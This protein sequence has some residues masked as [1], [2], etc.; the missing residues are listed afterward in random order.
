MKRIFTLLLLTLVLPLFLLAAAPTVTAS[1]PLFKNLDGTRFSGEFTKG[2]GTYRIVVMKE[3]SPVTGLPQNGKD[4]TYNEKFGTAG[5]EFTQPGEFV[6]MNT[7][8]TS[9]YPTNLKPGTTYH[10]A[11]FEYNGKGTATEYLMLPLTGSVTT[12]VAP[13]APVSNLASPAQTGNTITLSWA[14]GNGSGRLVVARKGAAVNVLPADLTD[15]SYG[16]NNL[17][18]APSW[19]STT[20]WCTK[21]RVL[22]WW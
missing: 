5:S 6:V 14:A 11:V 1:N 15:Y 4:Y 17:V 20:S 13:T 21:A 7:S 16:D 9:Y 12:V 19:A 10:I 3:G 8:W 18:T 22:R 2:N